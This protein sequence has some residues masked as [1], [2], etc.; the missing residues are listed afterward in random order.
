MQLKVI[1]PEGTV[2]KDVTAEAF[3]VPV[4]NGAHGILRNHAPMVAALQPGVL[5]YQDGAGWEKVAV[6]GGFAEFSD[7]RLTVLA[8]TAE[9]ATNVDVARAK[10][11]L[12]RAQKRLADKAAGVDRERALKSAARALARLQAA[13]VLEEGVLTK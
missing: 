12:E 10:A 5:K 4:L 1:T 8:D 13:G 9:L 6:S 11:S 7:N 3:I 2:T